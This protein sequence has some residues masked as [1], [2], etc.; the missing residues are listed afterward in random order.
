MK[1]NLIYELECS[2]CKEQYIGET[3]RH[4]RT[5]LREHY[6]DVQNKKSALGNHYNTIHQSET[7][8]QN[9]FDVKILKGECKD[10]VD[11]KIWEAVLI[12]NNIPTINC[13]H[14]ALNNTKKEYD[15]DTWSLIQ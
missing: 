10:W 4:L 12:K 13:Q 5:R 2:I 11:R 6:R 1:K 8:P 14:N 7:I 3:C 9:P 15:V